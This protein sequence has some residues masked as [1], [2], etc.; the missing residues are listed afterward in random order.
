MFAVPVRAGCLAGHRPRARSDAMTFEDRFTVAAP[1]EKVWAFL[2]D[3]EQVGACIPGTELIEVVDDTHYHVVAG[4]RVSF[5]SLS[6]AMN[7]T[8][9]EIEEP[10]RLVSMAEGIDSRIKERVKLGAALTLEPHGPITT[11]VGYRIDLTVFG[12]LASLGFT[13]IKG[14]A[15][16]MAADFATCIRTR[17]EAAA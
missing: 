10:R 3:P 5:L 2:R 7:V 1:I 12:K 15:R 8:V 4:A 6:F 17:L 14:K 11:E 16:Q 9:T 13:V